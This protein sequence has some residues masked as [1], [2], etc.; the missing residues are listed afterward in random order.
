MA[1][2]CLIDINKAVHKPTSLSYLEGAAIANSSV[3]AMLSVQDAGP[4][5]DNARILVLGGSSGVGSIIIQLLKIKSPQCFIASTSTDIELL[6][7]LN[8]DKPINYKNENWYEIED[9]KNNPFD[10]IF[11]CAEGNSAWLHAKQDH[12]LK[13]G[14]Q[15]GV[16]LSVV[17]LNHTFELHTLYQVLGIMNSMIGRPLYTKIN[18]CCMPRYIMLFGAPRNHSLLELIRLYEKT[19][20]KVI[21][22]PSS[23]F[24][25]TEEG[26]KSAYKLQGSRRAHGKVVVAITD[27]D[28]N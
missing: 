24:P 14:Y 28:K 15:G 17:G 16:F 8:V 18:S 7:L 6:K 19:P 20:F 22:D 27:S 5:G 26:V 23:P 10:K 9:F 13:T 12:L 4:I 21:L 1:E 11:D 3:N 25:F 2:Y